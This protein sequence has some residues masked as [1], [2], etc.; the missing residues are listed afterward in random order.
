MNHYNRGHR[1]DLLV[2][3]SCV[4]IYG[5]CCGRHKDKV[6]YKGLLVLLSED[7]L[8]VDAAV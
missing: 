4:A 2:H 1:E 8:N 6:C 5:E 7:D 3:D